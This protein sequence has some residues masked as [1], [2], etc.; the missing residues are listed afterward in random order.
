[1][2]RLLCESKYRVYVPWE[3]YQKDCPKVLVVCSGQHTHPI[4]L[5]T[6][7]PPTL[8]AE[9]LRLMESLE[10]DLPDL[11]PRRFIR[12]PTVCAYVR[13]RLPHM[14]NPMLSD[15]HPSLA[16]QDH[17]RAYIRQAQSKCLPCGT[18]WEG[19]DYLTCISYFLT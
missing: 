16:N 8:R 17:L 14:H 18:D 1:M 15:L 2:Q 6:K 9:L 4:P 11:T 12:H 7:T 10:H 5:P 13:N 3:S 19:E